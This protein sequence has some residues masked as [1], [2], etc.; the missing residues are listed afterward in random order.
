L[1]QDLSG[2]AYTET[3]SVTRSNLAQTGQKQLL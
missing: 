3:F 1:K 2:P